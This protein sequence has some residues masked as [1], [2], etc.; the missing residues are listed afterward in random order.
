M[1]GLFV[2][3]WTIVRVFQLRERRAAFLGQ[4]GIATVVG[5]LLA[6][7]VVVAF[8]H[9]LG[10]GFVSYHSGAVNN[11]SYPA[12][13]LAS[14]GLKYITSPLGLGGLGETQA[15]Y[16]TLPAIVLAVVALGHRR[17]RGLKL[18]AV[19][20]FLV[21]VGNMYGFTPVKVVLN[22]VPGFSGILGLKYCLPIIMLAVALL[23]AY[24]VDHLV[25]GEL[26][27]GWIAAAGVVGGGYLV[28]AVVYCIADNRFHRGGWSVFYLTWAL[29][30]CAGVCAVMLRSKVAPRSLA[31]LGLVAGALVC[32]DAAGNYAVPQLSASSRQ[33]IDLGPVRYLQAHLGTSRFYTLGPIQPNYGSY[34]GIAQL[35]ANDLPVPQKYADYVTERLTPPDK[36]AN[37][38][39]ISR[40]YLP[41]ELTAFNYPVWGQR[42]L[43]DAYGQ[44]QQ[45]FRDAAVEYVV[46]APGV[47][48]QAS[49]DRLGLSLVYSDSTAQIWRDAAAKPYYESAAGRCRVLEQTYFGVTVDCTAADTLQ[50]RALS[51]PGWTADINGRSVALHD[52]D[53]TLFQSVPVPVGRST[54]EFSYL[55]K[56]FTPAVVISLALCALMLAEGAFGL[57]RRSRPGR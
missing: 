8:L 5:V 23:A 38:A 19:G 2:A 18:L 32:L 13:Y 14:L 49:A 10:F 47:V 54:I 40:A 7:P 24:G 31:A 44:R 46:T 16:V 12:A 15:G 35:N 48:S 37:P 57:R 39:F 41:Y 30:A 9:F 33:P 43:L 29:V 3:A 42:I 55:P 11:Q 36:S 28:A 34:F 56:Y 52:D 21:L 25:R 53:N 27:R 51:S 45:Y 22:H 6:L 50:R 26:R 1:Q 17:D 20:A 4:V